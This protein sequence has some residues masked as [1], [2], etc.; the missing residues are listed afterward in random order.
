M[1]HSFLSPFFYNCMVSLL[2]VF[3]ISDARVNRVHRRF[4]G[5]ESDTESD[6]NQRFQNHNDDNESINETTENNGTGESNAVTFDQLIKVLDNFFPANH[7]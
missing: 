1:V 3:E 5:D 4:E 7:H 2:Q 6:E